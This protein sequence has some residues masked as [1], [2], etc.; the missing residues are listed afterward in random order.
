MMW[1]FA[2]ISLSA[3]LTEEAADSTDAFTLPFSFLPRSVTPNPS[4]PT[5]TSSLEDQVSLCP[6]V[7]RVRRRRGGGGG[8]F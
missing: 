1:L 2:G 6:S 4:P 3:W 7:E 5:S 8:L